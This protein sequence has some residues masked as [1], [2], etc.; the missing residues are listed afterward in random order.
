MAERLEWVEIIEPRTRERMYANLLTGECVWDPPQGVRIKRTGDNQWWELFDPNTSRFYYYNA[1]TQRTVWHRPQ[2]CDI[3]PLAKLQTLKQHTDASSSSPQPGDEPPTHNSPGRNSAVSQEGSTCS[4]VE[5][6]TSDKQKERDV[7]D[8][9][10]PFRWNTGTKERMLIK[11][12]DRE[13]SFLAHQDNGFS[14]TEPPARSRHS[15]GGNSSEADIYAERRH[16]P[17]LK[18]AELGGAGP[19]R[20]S[21]SDSQ[22]ASPRY[23][24]EPPLYEEPPSDYQPPPIYE[25]PPSDMQLS[26]ESSSLYGSTKSPARK[27]PVPLYHSP[28]QS[29]YGQLVLTRQK[30]PEKAQ[31]LEYSPVGKEYVKQLVYVEQSSS[32]PRFRTADR[33]LR[34]GTTTGY[35]GSYGGSFTLQHSQSLIRD[36]R[37]LLDYSG[38][39]DSQKLLYE[40]SISWSASHTHISSTIGPGPFSPGGNRKRK[41]RKPSLPQELARCGTVGTGGTEADCASPSEAMLAQARLAWEAQQVMKQRSSWDSGQTGGSKDG[42]ESDGAVPLPLPGPVVRAFSEDEGL[43]QSEQHWKRSTFDRLGFP[44]ALL[45]KSLSVQTNLASPEPYLHPSQSEDLG[46]CAQFEASRNARNMMPSASCGVF[47][48]FSL[49]KPSS[50]TDIENW[51][52]KHFNKHTQGLFRRKVSIANMLA[53]SSEPIKK[54]MIVTSDRSVKKEAVDLFK[55]IQ[56]FMG[57]RRCKAE[58]LSVA[59]EVVVRGWSNQGL[60]DELYIQLCRQTTENFR[61]DSLERGWELMAICLAFFPPTPRFHNYLEGYIQRH[62]DPLNDNKGVAISS[63][64]KYCYRKLTKAALT[65]AKKRATEGHRGPQRAAEGRRGPQ[66]AAA[67]GRSRGPQQRAAAEGRS[68]GPQQRAAAEGRSRGPQQRAAAEGRSR[69]PQQRAAAE[70]RSRGPQRAAEGRSRGPQQRAAAEGRSRG[71]QRAAAEGRSR[72]PQQRAAAEGRSRGP[73]QRAAAEGRSRGQQRAAEGR[74]ALH[75][76]D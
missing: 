56:T 74:R 38:E 68:R 26:A 43:A 44:Q 29:P 39:G 63:Y 31:S 36:P 42:Y 49:R 10:S 21:S 25:E 72:G 13:P 37:L 17:F 3:I 51:A 59:L 41:S 18:R 40:D 27:S 48:E 61:Y 14:S 71:Q 9:T 53:W 30:C 34:L 24:Y 22:P 19:N 55:L 52:S 23:A 50:E 66:R 33:L 7:S 46:A 54:P 6:D 20:R 57:D 73:Q 60:R 28:K 1:S 35:G 32:S 65:G 11:V 15:S 75:M 69:G 45:E 76:S 12:T 2:S 70:G 58:P 64:A 5:Q 62:M 8:R 67:E 47:P 16:S 4:S